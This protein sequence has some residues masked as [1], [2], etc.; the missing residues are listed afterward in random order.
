MDKRTEQ[1]QMFKQYLERRAPGRRTSIDYV[2]DVYQFAASCSK[3]WA[4]V[5]MHDIDAFVDQQRQKGLS[6]ATIKRRV[7][8]LR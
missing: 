7:A 2:S 3:P 5:T 1:I 4:E 6:A 8:V